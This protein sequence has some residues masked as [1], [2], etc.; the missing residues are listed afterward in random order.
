[1]TLIRLLVSMVV[2]AGI[3]MMSPAASVSQDEGNFEIRL[4]DEFKESVEPFAKLR[5]HG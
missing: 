2:L 3:G 5:S 4:S 1:M